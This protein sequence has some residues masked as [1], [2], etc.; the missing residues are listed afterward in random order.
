MI[1]NAVKRFWYSG[2]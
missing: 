1:S 2:N